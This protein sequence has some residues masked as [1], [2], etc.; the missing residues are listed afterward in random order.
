M[1]TSFY[2]GLSGMKSQQVGIDIWGNNIS[3]ID[4]AGYKQQNVDFSSLFS[5]SLTTS[6]GSPVSSDIG[7]S[8]TATTSVMDLSQGSIEQTD[9]VFDLALNGQGWMAIK[10]GNNDVYYTRTGS[11]TKDANGTLVTQSG[12]KLQVVSADNLTFDGKNWKFN[13]TIPTDNLVKDG[14]QTTSI[15]LPDNIVFPPQ[16]TT[17]VSLSGNLPNETIAPTP[18]VATPE[19]DLGVLYDANAQNIN[20]QNGQDVMFGFGKNIAYS[21]GMIR[22]DICVPD[23][24]LDGKNVNINFD[25]NGENIKLELPDGSSSKTIVDAI[26]KELDKKN[27]LYDKTNNSIQLKNPK[28]LFVKSNGGDLIKENSVMQQLVYD[29][30][31]NKDEKFTT[32]KDFQDKLQT[33]ANSVYGNDATV[34]IDENG[35]LNIT[36]NTDNK[37]II[38]SSFKT[39]NS[40]DL[41]IQNLS[42]LGSI[43]KSNTSSSSLTFNQNYQGFSGNIV[44]ANGNKNDLKFDFYKT[45]IDGGNTIWTL[46]LSEVDKDGKVLSSQKENLTFNNNGGL[47]SPTKIDF[48]NN[49]ITTKIDLGG[50]FL[51]I[52][53]IDKANTGFAYAQDGFVEGNLVN[54]DISDNGEIIANFSNS[55]SGILGQ[56]PIYHF[57]NE[58]GLDS[59]GGNKFTQTANSGKA[60]LYKDINGDYLAGAKTQNYALESSNVSMG[61]AMTELIIIQKAF[62]AN[63]KSV[64]TSDKMVQRAI[65]MKR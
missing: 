1:N 15:N 17:K 65:D 9:K 41:F 26:T 47:I 32:L 40:N 52:T 27:I 4:T 20:M 39:E 60:F 24:E 22:Y 21:N 29:S 43:I 48:N 37:E 28:T 25:V 23:D 54:Y 16:P 8:S 64:T 6:L 2:N 62:D 58:Q 3:N 12:E 38:A 18:R 10:D 59:I 56:I 11:F 63:S 57:Q 55:N 36:N 30:T 44:D 45:K 34:S 31:S 50:A 49:G 53:A 7:L 19:S 14:I 35:K 33:L 13:A 42:R 61:Q 5:A 51:G 46:T